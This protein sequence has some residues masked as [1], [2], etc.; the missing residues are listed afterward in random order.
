MFD[1]EDEEFNDIIDEQGALVGEKFLM[2]EFVA[3]QGEAKK[4]MQTIETL[5]ERDAKSR[6]RNNSNIPQSQNNVGQSPYRY[7]IASRNDGRPPTRPIT[8]IKSS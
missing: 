5:M 8:P 2:S 7:S 1:A 4:Q 6:T 3:D